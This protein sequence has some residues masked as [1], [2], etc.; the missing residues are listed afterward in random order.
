MEDRL[1][2]NVPYIV[3]EG[4]MVRNER[5]IKRLIISLVVSIIFIFIS[6]A[7]WLYAWLQ[8]DYESSE[9]QTISVDGKDGNA[10][11]IGNDGSIV[12]GEDSSK[13]QEKT[14]TD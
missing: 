3:H 2:D 5:I 9:L 13:N 6:N 4:A 8:Y 7:V 12:N 1:P 10:N 11:Y 14:E